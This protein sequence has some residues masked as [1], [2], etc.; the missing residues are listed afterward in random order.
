MNIGIL[1]GAGASKDIHPTFGIGIDLINQIKERVLEPGSPMPYLSQLL[2]DKL[3][4]S[5]EHRK[6]FVAALESYINEAESPTIDEFLNEVEMYPDYLD[7]REVYI[8][9]G[10]VAI[11]FHIVGWEGMLKSSIDDEKTNLLNSWLG[12]IIKYIENKKLLNAYSENPILAES[13]LQIITF[14]Y[15]RIIEY[16]LKKHFKT[17][18]K[19]IDAW[20]NNNVFH[21]YGKVGTLDEIEF[22]FD[23]SQ[24][25]DLKNY[26]GNIN[27]MYNKR[28]E[29]Q[30]PRD[31]WQSNYDKVRKN[32]DASTAIVNASSKLLVF[33][34]GYDSFNVKQVYLNQFHY[35]L[36]TH[37]YSEDSKSRRAKVRHIR[38]LFPEIEFNF[39]TCKEFLRQVL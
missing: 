5:I 7:V 38:N 3:N 22:G 16:G 6:G 15:D 32:W 34:F 39:N 17:Q 30:N 31:I 28:K 13:S 29:A 4:I 24:V 35:P 9:I 36:F 27:I 12:E 14:N 20:I 23:N 21:V 10:F 37:I 25:V 19:E 8:T 1:I 26:I 33:G 11:L 18:P 2:N